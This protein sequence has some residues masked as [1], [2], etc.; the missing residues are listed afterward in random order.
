MHA[1]HLYVCTS[2]DGDKERKKEPKDDT[3]KSCTTV[4][5][6][7][8][9]FIVPFLLSISPSLPLSRSS[10]G[11]LTQRARALFTLSL[12]FLHLD[13][14]FS[15]SFCTCCTTSTILFLASSLRLSSFNEASSYTTMKN[16]ASK[17]ASNLATAHP[18]SILDFFS[19]AGLRSFKAK[20]VGER[21]R[22]R[23]N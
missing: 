3:K 11:L 14:D 16:Q 4:P 17:P 12:S 13:V 5:S 22:E 10:Q 9:S 7:V 15:G 6:F 20:K 18:S 23:P 19:F 1:L 8:G 21:E 2:T